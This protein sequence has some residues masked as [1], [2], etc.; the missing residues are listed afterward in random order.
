M[1]S[2]ARNAASAQPMIPPPT[3]ATSAFGLTGGRLTSGMSPT[4]EQW[5]AQFAEALGRPAPDAAQMEAVPSSPPSPRMRPSAR[6]P[7]SRAGSR[8]VTTSPMR[9]RPPSAQRSA[10][11]ARASASGSLIPRARPPRP[12]PRAAPQ[13]GQH[14][15]HGGLALE[16]GAQH[17]QRGGLVAG[18]NASPGGAATP[19][20]AASRA[21]SSAVTNGMS[22]ASAT[23]GPAARSSA[24]TRPVSGCAGAPA[25]PTPARRAPG[26]PTR[27]SRRPR[28]PTPPPRR[29]RGA[30]R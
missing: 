13:L 11:S 12:P 26:A 15:P 18:G 28:P 16:P 29:P 20:A 30:T 4:A 23:I 2:S 17:G 27:A 21:I 6:R 7:R 19:R 8:P 24:A 10:A 22:Q 9:C 25:P 5:I 14:R 3:M 1:P